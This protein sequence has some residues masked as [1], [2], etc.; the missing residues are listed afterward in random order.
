MACLNPGGV[1][2]CHDVLPETEGRTNIYE[3]GEVYKSIGAVRFNYPNKV[4]TWAGDCGC[5]VIYSE[6]EGTSGVEINTF[7]DYLDNKKVYNIVE[8][9]KDL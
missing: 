2:V 1:I 5:A 9:F 8:D 7:Q 4:R 3:C 6:T